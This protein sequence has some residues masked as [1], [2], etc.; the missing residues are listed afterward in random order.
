MRRS[1]PGFGLIDIAIAICVLALLASF[2]VPVYK[3]KEDRVKYKRS[4]AELKRVAEAME[5]HYLESG[6]YPVFES[7][8]EIAGTDN[9]LVQ[10]EYIEKVPQSDQW[11]RSFIGKSSETEYKLEGFSIPSNNK[12]VVS[13]FPDYHFKTGAKL[14]QKGKKG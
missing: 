12:K 3:G 10:G 1:S 11:D 13:K 6:R 4:V 7:W 9:P 14:V 8:A 5:K 2:I